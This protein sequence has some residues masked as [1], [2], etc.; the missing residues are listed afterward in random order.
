TALQIAT[1]T[2]SKLTVSA[3]LS[4]SGFSLGT[5]ALTGDVTTTTNSFSTTIAAAAVT[6][7]KMANMAAQTIKSNA[8]GSPAAPSDNTLTAL[9]DAIIGTGRGSIVVR[10]ASSWTVLALG[11]SG[12][13][14]QSNGTDLVYGGSGGLLNYQ[15]Y[16]LFPL[17]IA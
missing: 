5:A 11:S 17:G 14:L 15:E 2:I 10:G 4:L 13:V 12:Q 7:S 3:S 1:H 16:V 9:L 8:T 6:N